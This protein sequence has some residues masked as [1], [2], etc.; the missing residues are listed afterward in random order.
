[1]IKVRVRVRI[2]AAMVWVMVTDIV[3]TTPTLILDPNP[4]N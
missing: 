2:V 3:N 1:M 4:C